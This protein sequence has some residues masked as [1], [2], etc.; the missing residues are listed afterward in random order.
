MRKGVNCSLLLKG[1]VW[2]NKIKLSKILTWKGEIWPSTHR[3]KWGKSWSFLLCSFLELHASVIGTCS[4]AGN[5]LMTS[6]LLL[7]CL[8]IVNF[9]LE[10]VEKSKAAQSVFMCKSVPQWHKKSMRVLRAITGEW[11]RQLIHP[12]CRRDQFPMETLKK[13]L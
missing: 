9:H 7:S 12:L 2:T 5:V 6:V 4:P 10:L 3:R 8:V 13:S 11:G 1:D